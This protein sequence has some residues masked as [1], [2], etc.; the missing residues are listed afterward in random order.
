[1]VEAFKALLQQFR[2]PKVACQSWLYVT[3]RKGAAELLRCDC[4]AVSLNLRSK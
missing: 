2:C 3:P 4:M 1:M